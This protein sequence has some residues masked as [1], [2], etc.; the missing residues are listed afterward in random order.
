[1]VE[2]AEGPFELGAP[3]RRL[4]LRQRAPAPHASPPARFTIGRTPVT[5]ATWQAWAEDGGYTRREWWSDAGWAWRTEHDITDHAG[6]PPDAPVVHVSF[7][8]ADAFARAH[9]ARLPTEVEWEKAAPGQLEGIGEVWEWTASRVHRLPGFQSAPVPGVLRGVLRRPLP[10]AARRLLRHPPTRRLPAL[11]QLGPPRTPAALR[12][13][14]DRAMKTAFKDIE[15]VSRL[16]A[17][18]RTLAYD[19]ADGLTRPFKE[20]PPKHFYDTEGSRLFEAITKLPEYY[21][22]RTERAILEA[23]AAH[24]V[25]LTRHGRAGRARLRRADQ[26]A[27]AAGRDARGRDARPLRAVRRL[28]GRAA[29]ERGDARRALPGRA[30]VRRRG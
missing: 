22:T 27:A 24:L 29:R 30:R 28:R 7:H 20:I 9:N 12:R 6:G 16:G 26:D 23:N 14:Q 8:E 11:P 21:P 19:V 13:S 3:R 25:E 15:I 10:G 18:E 5:N 1:M 4:R 17:D 2:I